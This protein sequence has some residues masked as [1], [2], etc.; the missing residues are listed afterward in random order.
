[1]M[2]SFLKFA[3]LATLGEVIAYLIIHKKFPNREFGLFPRAFIWGLFGIVIYWNFIIFSK[4]VPHLLGELSSH[5]VLTAFAISFFMN[6]IFAPVFM[7]FHKITDAHISSHQ[8]KFSSLFSPIHIEKHI[9][10][11]DWRR[12]WNFVLK[13]TIPLFWIP[14]HTITFLLPPQ[15]RILFAAILGVILGLILALSTNLN[16][17]K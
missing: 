4:G 13:K 5:Q 11:I 15:W 7:T 3:I 9:Q 1:M 8:G 2:M 14:A 10:N 6:V 16:Q 12:H 17:H